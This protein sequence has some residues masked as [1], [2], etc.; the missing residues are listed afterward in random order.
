[1][2]ERERKEGRETEEAVIRVPIVCFF[3]RLFFIFWYK[4]IGIK[5]PYF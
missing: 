5:V 1:M 4:G 3:I 2:K